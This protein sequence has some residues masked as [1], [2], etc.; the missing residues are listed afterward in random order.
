MYKLYV[1][2]EPVSCPRT[3]IHDAHAAYDS[4]GIRRKSGWTIKSGG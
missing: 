2:E 1:Y 3:Y 4:G